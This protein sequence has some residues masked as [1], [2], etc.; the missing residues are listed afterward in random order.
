MEVKIA[1][2][3]YPR[4]EGWKHVWI[5]NHSS[6]HKATA[7]DSLDVS[8]KNMKLG[9]KRHVMWEASSH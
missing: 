4:D 9:G 3:K 6:S 5:F 1:E 8:K 7:D 2:A